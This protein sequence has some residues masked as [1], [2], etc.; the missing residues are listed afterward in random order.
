MGQAPLFG[1][2]L[3]N[4]LPF[5]TPLEIV[6][7]ASPIYSISLPNSVYVGC[8]HES[9]PN[10]DIYTRVIDRSQTFVPPLNSSSSDLRTLLT[11]QLQSVYGFQKITISCNSLSTL[12][13]PA[14]DSTQRRLLWAT[15]AATSTFV[16]PAWS[17]SLTDHIVTRYRVGAYPLA[18]NRR[19]CVQLDTY[20]QQQSISLSTNPL[21]AVPQ[22]RF[23][24]LLLLSIPKKDV[25]F[26]HFTSS[27]VHFE[28]HSANRNL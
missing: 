15:S 3:I 13:L 20:Q 12:Q 8:E 22:R 28:H 26:A 24:F 11:D 21:N 18:P 7:P 6:D 23:F 9:I 5:D 17:V 2:T 4:P 10:V 27:S 19:L 16:A 25:L 1:G 14:I